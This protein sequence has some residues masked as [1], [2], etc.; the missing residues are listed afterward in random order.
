M[1]SIIMGAFARATS[2]YFHD[3]KKHGGINGRAAMHKV[4][5]I[6]IHC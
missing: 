5:M 2:D 3:A 6:D 4:V 1:M